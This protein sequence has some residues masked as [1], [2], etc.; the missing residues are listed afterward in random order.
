MSPVQESRKYSHSTVIFREALPSDLAFLMQLEQT[1][2]PEHRQSSRES[3]RRSI[4]SSS[5]LVVIAERRGR[6]RCLPIGVAVVFLFKRTLRIYS[7]A[8]D[9]RHRVAG[10]GS[11]MMQY[12]LDFATNHGYER[13]LLEA[14]INNV[15]LVEWYSGMGFKPV[16]SL[17]DFYGPGE[18]AIKMVLQLTGKSSAAD[19]IVIVVDDA[20]AA[21][22]CLAS[23]KFVQAT[24]YLSD[25]NYANS[26]RF[27]VLN[28]CGTYKTHSLGYYVSLL[29]SAR[30]HRV[31]PSVMAVKDATT[32]SVAQSL[33]D[34]I[35]DYTTEKLPVDAGRPIELTCVLGMAPDSRYDEL[36]RKLFSLFSIPFFSVTLELQETWKVK[37]IKLLKL[38]QVADKYPELL[39]EALTRYGEKRRYSRP[40]L[41]NYKYDLAILI[42]GNEKT[43]PSCPTALDNFRKAAEKV[44]FFVEFISKSDHRRICEFDALFIRETTAMEDHTYAMARHA[45]TEG[46]VVVDDPWSIMLCSN[47]VYL[48]ERLTGAG[49]RQ[50]R[51][52]L[53]TQKNSSVT[54][55][56]SLPVPLVLKLPE[57]SFSQGVYLV[58]T[59]ED[60]Q[61]KL[62]EMFT[63]TE[64]VIAQEFLTS[65]YD[66]RIGLLDNTPL[67]ACKYYMANNHWQIYNWQTCESEE[68][69]GRHETLS[70]NQVPPHVLKAAI[71]ASS[72]IGNGFYG[73]DIKEINGK[74]YVIEVND[75]PNVDA[76]VEDALLGEELYERIMRSI[77]NR[78]ETERNQ[79][80]YLY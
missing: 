79:I 14:D 6:K 54:F 61:G 65:D 59:H 29:A 58:D 38:K 35:R 4:A 16:R 73:V 2:F 46:L 44:G 47:K 75:N 25:T 63:Q 10:V 13:I 53:L 23:M 17:P 80:R 31:T 3:L 72:L 12:I 76:G 15:R 33:L 7:L 8:V 50:P 34:E 22:K 77:F 66:W 43:P 68:F 20:V 41:K 9:E 55:L 26:S 42:N 37:K 67:F 71:G 28:L 27:H 48:H 52:W 45:Y 56:R 36:A 30:N 70:V 18:H 78:I 57:S 51:G 19:R 11:S 69:C 64:L 1:T 21:R 40:R 32:I 24:D 49:I 60:L 5:Q 39:N 62:K 74:A